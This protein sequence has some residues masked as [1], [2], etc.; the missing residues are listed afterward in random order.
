MR[1]A[2][3]WS[4][5]MA[6]LKALDLIHVR[7]LHQPQELAGI[8]REGFDIASLAFGVDGVKGQAG[9][10]RTRQ[11]GDHHQLVAR[12]LKVDVFQVVFAG[13]TNDELVLCHGSFFFGVT[14]RER[15]Q[16]H[17]ST[18]VLS[19]QRRLPPNRPDL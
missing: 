18:N 8:G 1:L 19:V 3:F 9:L 12:D 10:A 13:A 11:A 4:M 17:F 2:P 7:L 15:R 14:A 6:G 16:R 5:E